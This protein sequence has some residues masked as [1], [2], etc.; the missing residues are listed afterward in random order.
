VRLAALTRHGGRDQQVQGWRAVAT[1]R[2]LFYTKG[3][4]PTMGMYPML[5]TIG[6][7]QQHRSDSCTF[8]EPEITQQRMPAVIS[9]GDSEQLSPPMRLQA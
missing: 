5:L 2:S 9:T 3:R 7:A 6:S 4:V 8:E 1:Q